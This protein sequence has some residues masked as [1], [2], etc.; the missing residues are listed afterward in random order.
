MI[1]F[2][3]ITLKTGVIVPCGT[4]YSC[5]SN[6]RNQWTFRLSYEAKSSFSSF[7]VTLTYADEYCDMKLHK[8]DFQQFVKRFR[9]HNKQKIKYFCLGEY[10]PK[11]ERPHYH[12]LLFFKEYISVNKVYDLIKKEW[13]QGQIFIGQVEE[14][15]IHYCTSF[16]VDKGNTPKHLKKSN[17]SFTLM[18]TRPAIG[19]DYYD[20]NNLKSYHKDINNPFVTSKDGFKQAIPRLYKQKLYDE[21]E[22]EFM[23]LNLKEQYLVDKDKWLMLNPSKGLSH[24]DKYVEDYKKM[25]YLKQQKILKTKKL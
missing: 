2:N 10:G 21:Q 16:H 8:T 4:C 1:C 23:G 13:P 17:P 12:C 3:P 14:A 22:R 19:S 11:T 5:L 15:S 7:F 24:Y 6:K 9:R 25:A 20:S 18:S